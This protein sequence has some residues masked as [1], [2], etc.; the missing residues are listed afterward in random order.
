MEYKRQLI[1]FSSCVNREKGRRAGYAA[2]F[3]RG[4]LCEVQIYYRG[5]GKP[6]AGQKV[7]PVYLFLDGSAVE[8]EEIALQ[9][10]MAADGVKTA[11]ENFLGTGR[12]ITNLEAIYLEGTEY[13]ICGGRVDGQ[14]LFGEDNY[15]VTRWM[16]TV[17]DVMEQ[18]IAA[19][20]S[21]KEKW[22]ETAEM[23]GGKGRWEES[24][25]EIWSLAECV[26]KLPELKLP[27]DGV[28]RRCCRM[29]LEDMKHL[30]EEWEFLKKNHFLLHGYYEYHHLLL[31]KLSGRHGERFVLGVPGE[32]GMREQYMAENFGFQD[33]S[34]LEQ[35]KRRRGS[36][37]YWY[38]YLTKA[39]Y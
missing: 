28:R 15:S 10:G 29:T 7:Q 9:E 22:E 21:E 26:E 34:P 12:S 35:G 31:G 14:A 19:G 2:V 8:G 32:Y 24:K 13:G 25:D 37:G 11:T 5:E 18:E 39:S 4:E 38:Y 17:T 27:F 20:E 23:G 36:F 30:P 33:F 6:E 1:Y 16:D 3:I